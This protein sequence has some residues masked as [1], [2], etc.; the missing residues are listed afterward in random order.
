MK[1]SIVSRAALIILAIVL[2]AFGVFHFQHARE[3]IVFVPAFVP[4]GIIWVYVVGIAFIL[5]A[6]ALIAHR[7]VKVAGYLLALLLLLFVITIHLP[8]WMDSGD[9]EMRQQALTNLLKDSAIAA[10]A[11]YIGSTAPKER[12]STRTD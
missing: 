11:L 2:A 10:F 5:V 8:N 9:A 4:G 6:I 7:Y 12:N 3:M 1:E